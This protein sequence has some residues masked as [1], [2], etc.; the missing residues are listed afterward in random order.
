M[1]TVAV[2]IAVYNEQA[3]IDS[4]IDS[5]LGQTRPP[6]EI[7]L[8][9]DGSRDDTAK[10]IKARAQRDARIRYVYQDN[11]GPATARNRAWREASCDIC[12]FTDGDCVPDGNWI[13]TLIAPF[14]DANVGATAG[15]Y[16]TL[17]ADNLLARFVG[18]EIAWRYRNVG[19]SVDC[20]GTYNLAIRRDVLLELGGFDES[21][22]YP[23]GEDFDLTYRISRKHRIAFVRAAVVGHEHPD[24]LWPY[25]KLQSRRAL[26]RVRLY[27]AHRDKSGSDTYTSPLE[28]YQVLASGMLLGAP[29]LALIDTRAAAL[30]GGALFGFLLLTALHPFA[31]VWRQAPAAAV[32]GTWVRLLRNFAWG[33]GVVRGLLALI[34]VKAM[35]SATSKTT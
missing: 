7:V 15:T 8:V 6:D 16:R 14:E 34:S 9:D 5:L 17:N 12:V 25:L 4:L 31:F 3:L 21:Y 35:A 23:S 13:E 22:R 18:A 20:H 32:Y 29:A 24:A 27:R 10:L 19:D 28:K 33:F 11:A 2:T 26:D 30:A 1:P